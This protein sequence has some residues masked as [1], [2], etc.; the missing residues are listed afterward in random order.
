MVSF[1]AAKT[2]RILDVSVAWVRLFMLVKAKITGLPN[3]LRIQVEMS[4]INLVET[5]E[6]VF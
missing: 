6:E 1:T 3:I 5:P 4:S 2:S